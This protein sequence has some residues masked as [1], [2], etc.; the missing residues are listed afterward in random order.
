MKLLTLRIIGKENYL[1]DQILIQNKR[2]PNS[3]ESLR[4]LLITSKKIA[5]GMKCGRE[6]NINDNLSI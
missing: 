5:S 6:N 4:R 1:K 3:Q 2:S